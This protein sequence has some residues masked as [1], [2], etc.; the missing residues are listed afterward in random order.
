MVT[1]RRS[2][3]KPQ[4][5]RL[6]VE[7]AEVKPL[8]WRMLWVEGQFT[9]MQLHHIVQAVMGWTDAHLH[10]FSI[11]GKRYATPHEEDLIETPPIDERTVRLGDLLSV[12]LRFDYLY[13]FGDDWLHHIAV[14]E[15][16]PLK[17]PYG[18]AHVEA[19]A[20]AC[21]PEDCGGPYGY[22]AFLDGLANDPR[23]E[24]IVS[25]L[26][27]TGKDFNP[28]RFDRHAANAALLRMAWNRW[29]ER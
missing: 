3:T 10:Q 27:W 5:Y 17:E 29:G 6:R 28:D 16:V 23:N 19:G 24:E 7:L 25:F 1:R 26:D 4:R 22:Q 14:E 12:G 15:A 20:R 21:P 11:G 2:T 9:L 8:I 13:D 18:A